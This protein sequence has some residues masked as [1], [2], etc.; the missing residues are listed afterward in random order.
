MNQYGSLKKIVGWVERSETQQSHGSV[1]FRS[2]TQPTQK[3]SFRLNPSVLKRHLWL[4]RFQKALGMAWSLESSGDKH[5]S[6][7]IEGSDLCGKA[8]WQWVFTIIEP[9]NYALAIA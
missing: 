4:R 1:G 9:K 7:V 8:L 5:K 2:L 6:K 3:L